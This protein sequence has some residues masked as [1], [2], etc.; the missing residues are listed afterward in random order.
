MAVIAVGWTVGSFVASLDKLGED[1]QDPIRLLIYDSQLVPKP[2]V[3][4][5]IP[6]T[7]TLTVTLAA[8]LVTWLIPPSFSKM[9]TIPHTPHPIRHP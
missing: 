6:L 7:Y 1:K 9:A 4:P 5:A 8:A 3:E 2:W